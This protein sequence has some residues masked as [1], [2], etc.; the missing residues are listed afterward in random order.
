MQ[1]FHVPL[2]DPVYGNEEGDGFELSEYD[3]ESIYPVSLEGLQSPR[4]FLIH[5]P[6][7]T[8]EPLSILDVEAG[9][10][11]KK[12]RNG[13]ETVTRANPT[14]ANPTTANDSTP[15][16][17]QPISTSAEPSTVIAPEPKVTTSIA[18][19]KLFNPYTTVMSFVEENAD[20]RMQEFHVPLRDPVYGNK[21]GDGFELSEYDQ[22]SI[23]PVSLEGLQ[24]PRRFLIHDP[25]DTEEPLSILDVEAGTITKKHRNGEETVTRANPTPANPTT[26]NDSTPTASQPI[27]T[28]A[29][30][31]TVIAPEPK[32]TT[33][34]A[35]PKLFNPYTTVMSFVEENADPR[36]QE[37]HV[38]LRDPVYGN[39]EGDGFELS[40]YDQE[41]IYPVSLEGLQSP[42]RF[43]IHDPKDTE[44]PLSILDVE[45]G[46]ITKKH[47]NGEETVTRVVT[48]MMTLMCNSA[49]PTPAN[50]TTAN[51]STPT[52][53]QP[54]S[55]SAEPSTVIAPEPKVTTSIAAPKLFNPYT[56]VMSFVE[57]NADPRMQEF[58]VP[59]RDPVYGNEE[60]DGF[61]LSEYD[62][63]SIYP[64]SLEGLQSPRR[65]L[66]HDPKDTEEPLSI[67]DVEAGTITK[68]HRNGEE[69]VTRA[70]PTP[71]N[72]TTAND[73]TPTASQPISTSA[74]PSTV[75]APEPKVTT[76]IA[77]PKLFN[78]YTTVMSFVEENADPRMQ[79]FHVPLRDPVYGNEE[80]DGFELSEYDQES[81]Y[82]VSLEGLQSPRRFLIHDP[83][84]TEEPL[85]ILDVEAGTITK[86]HR[87][88]EETVTRVVTPMMTLMC[89]SANPTPANPTTANDSTPTASQPISTS[90]EPST[91]IAP[92]PKVTTSIAAPKLFNPHTTVMSF[93]E[94]N[95][96]PRMQEFHVPLRDPVY[97]NEEGDGFELSEY[98]Q[99]SIYPVS[100]EGL[101][102][103]RRFLI[104][105]PKDTEEPLS[106]LDVE[107]GTITKKHRNGEEIVTRANPT[108]ANPTTA[109][110]STPTA[111][112]P[113]STSAEPSTVIAPEP[114]V[115]TSIAAPKLFNPYTTVMSFV[116]ENADPRMQEFHVPLRDPV[117]GNEEGDGFELS[118]YDQ[119]SI[120]PVSLEGLQS[121]RRFLIHD[122]KD[123][124]ERLSILDVEA[125]TITKKHRNGEE[126]VTRVVTHMKTLM[127]NS[128]WRAAREDLNEYVK[129]TRPTPSPSTPTDQTPR[130]DLRLRYEIL[131][132]LYKEN[133]LPPFVIPEAM[134]TSCSTTTEANPTPAT[135]AN[136]T[137]AN[138]STPTAS[139]PI[140]T[141]AEP[142]TVIAPEPKVTTSIAAPKLFNPYTTVMSFV[143]ENADP[144]MQ[145][146]HVPLRDPVYGNEEGDGFELSEYDQESIYPVSLEGLQSPRRF[147]IHDPKDTEEPLSILD[148][149]A[150]TITK[151]HRNGEETVTRANPTPA[152][153]TTA[154]DSTP[155][156]SQPISTSAEPSTVIAP[157]PKVTTSIAAPKLFNP[158]TTVMSFVEENADPRMQEF[159]VPLR[160]PVYGNEEGDGFELSE[161]DQESIYPVSL[162]GLQSPRRFLI[163]DPKDTEERLSILDV[164]AGTIT[165]KHR[166]GEETVTRA[167]PTPANPTTAN[168]S[169]PTAS[170]PISTSAEPSTVIAPEPKVTTS[171][172]APK[173]FNPY[174]TV[175][176]F[177]EENADPRMQEFHVPLRDPVYGNEEGDGF[178]L[179][180]YDQES[181]YPVSLEGL[182]SPRR[183]LIHD[184][185]DTEEPLSILD[186]EAGTITK[187]H[188]NGEET[189]TRVVT[190]MKTLM[191]N[192]VWRAARED[193][194][195][196][197]KATRPTPSPSTPTDQTPRG[198]LRLRYEILKELYKENNLPPFVIPEA[199]F[200]SCST[201]TEANPTPA[202][203]ANP[204]TAN[205]STPTAS[206]PISTSAE[207]STVIA[208]EPKLT[209]SIA[210]PKLFNPYTTVMSFVEE[211]ADPRMQE[212]HV[213]LR[214]PV[215]GNEEGDGFELSE[216]DQE[217]IYPVS[218]EGLQSPRRFLIHDPKDTE[219]P[220][221]I[222]D[223]EAGTITKKHR[224]GEET[225]T[226]VVTH[227]K[228]L[229][230]NSVWRAAREDLNEYVKATRPT[231][232]PSTPTDQTPRG[233]L[234]LRY[235]ILKELYKE[236]NLPPFV[237][238]EAMFTSCSTTTE[239]NPTPATPANPTTANDS[240]PTAS[241]PISTSAEPSTVIAPE[242]K[243]TTS[244]AAPKLFNPYTTVMS[245]VEENADPRMQEFHVPLRDPVYGNE[246]GDGF[247][248]SEYDQESIY[249]VSLE[250]LQ[251]PRR[252]LIHDPKDTEEPLS[253][254][255]VEAGTITKKHRNG[256]ETVTR[257]VTHMKT[258][259]CN[260]V[261][262]AAREDLNEY[263]KATR[264]TPSPSTPTDQTPR[265]DLRLRY[266]I[267]KEL[268]KENN[269]PP[270]VIPEAM[271]TS[272]S[273][274]TEA[275]PTP[276]TPANPTTANDSTPT[277]SQP[278]STSAEPS[279]VIAPEPKVTTSIAAP[280]LFNP[281]TT[282]MSFVEENADPR[283]QEFHVP[284]RDPV[285]GNEEGDGFELSEYDQESIYPVSLEGLQS[286]R[287]FLI[288]DPK[289]TEEPLSILDVEAGTITKKHRNGEETVTRVVTH[290]KTLMCNSVWRAAREDLNEYVKATRPTP[291]PS[292]PTD[293]TPRGDLRLRYEIL[294]E[295]YKEN[296]LPPFVI[297]EAMFT[298]C[299]TT[300]EANPT[301]AT[302]ANPTTANDSTPTASQPISTSAEPSTVIAPEPKVTTS[303]AAPKLF[304][305][306]TTVMSF[307]EENADPRMQEFHVPLRDPVYGNE[308]GDG[309]ELSEYDQESIYPVSLEGLQS[310][311]RF[312]IHDP[313]DT[314][315]PLS[316][317]DVEAGTITKKHRNGEETVTR[318]VTH[319]KTL[320]CNS[321]WRA[322]R[323]DLN[324]Y[325]KATRPTP[326]PSTPTD[327]T[328]RGDLRLRYEILKELYKE[329]NLPPFVIPEAMFTCSTTTEANPTPATPANPTTAND[330]TPTASQPI[331]TSAEPSTVIA[332][333]PKVTTS[334]AAPKLFN[335]YT[336]VM[337]F[338]EENADPRMQEFHVPLRDPVYGNE[339][340]DGFE[341]SEYDQ[342]SIYPV[343]L[344]GLQ[345]P[346]R[347]LI[348]DPKDTE[349]PLSILDVEAGTITKK[350]RNGE[351]TVT[352]VVTHMKT[353]MCNSV[354]RAARE[355][356]NEYVKATRPTP[357][358]STPTDQTPRGDLR[359]RY[360]ILKELYKENNLPPF[361]IPEAMFTC[362]TTTEANPTP[363]TPANPT[364]ANDSTP[365]A[366]QPISTSAE[367]STVIAPEPKIPD[368]R[369]QGHRRTIVNPGRGSR[370]NNEET[371]KRRGNCYQG[372]NTHENPDVQQRMASSKRRLERICESDKT[373]TFTKHA[374]RPNSTQKNKEK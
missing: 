160:D 361:V 347:F 19:R 256:E 53:S 60:G 23:Y 253:I 305:P 211:N 331:S 190:H 307:V 185:K 229:M 167:N 153:P 245:F 371:Q 276:A 173:L 142:S 5:D 149:E 353:L 13:E 2:R 88:G 341:L 83:K 57:E 139:Q 170:Q 352:R 364:T 228:T 226:R 269:L 148:V 143:E 45:A 36:M 332:P 358:P 180:E 14:P 306:Y 165:K 325:V 300:T 128:V 217:S 311:R 233:D 7:D 43:L 33:S 178:E 313:K 205:D 216:Y 312:L 192:S 172:A 164:E 318:V 130:G 218:L 35:A 163:H 277:A 285:Y 102:S 136:P 303:I 117:Y 246:E 339:E 263:V 255:D 209:T 196:Y 316:I 215:Y 260:S 252:F 249:P 346:R 104:H 99:E 241:Q 179:S 114:K 110:D 191:C 68:K 24:S 344:E 147:L 140:S 113:I 302:P 267:L 176:S 198:D 284:L 356:L 154:N 120:Y 106:I 98:D 16:A 298:S 335:P 281:Y 122:P 11:T 97:G 270:F 338:V 310:P 184:P 266:E 237:I 46:T 34:I 372:S 370:N 359:L 204:T 363:A 25:K 289:D 62:Q 242:P 65:F 324:E 360:E 49:N 105:D 38:P 29:E 272:C 137:T 85:S 22:E 189:V 76:S 58:H 90:A 17:S 342:E 315:E 320:M 103:P 314:E 161:Y 78:P 28:S 308:E 51:D 100:L 101:Q 182:Q 297:P 271:F 329:N 52:A 61:E 118:E 268:Y 115:T 107:A 248:L 343:S 368:S 321:V 247:E 37:F 279:T 282:V 168:D 166:N 111:S 200:T 50:P 171:I 225:V 116:E 374:N 235:E 195:E 87:N 273:T 294:K 275:N 18:A 112:Q 238:P 299:S 27:S 348:H 283:M 257:V 121:P 42:R 323:E 286:P 21:E 278:I 309:F 125:G 72:P 10:I 89:N 244:I 322:A 158:Y 12:H 354:W 328:P 327:Q 186:V 4:R 124:E 169:T 239:A 264:P 59:L 156:A 73:S 224:N 202:T 301:P 236:N 232:S 138:D 93:V 221:S 330:S 274:T 265:G 108:P 39:E 129:A 150:G 317:L 295:L 177:V 3:Q 155:T 109:N 1:E 326:S 208:P 67:L 261:W 319:M 26:A 183:F 133:N 293:Q 288:H 362:S 132:E 81:I 9:T 357:S 259:M 188:R 251:S 82:P 144:R 96:D 54:I 94:E 243:V 287:R 220:L 250:G 55:T 146:F 92:E 30:P 349:E 187:K 162:E 44:E 80:G 296:N 193:L 258:L 71:A 151:K 48:P 214:D 15:T 337:S 230:C 95:A 127:C 203:P 69:T 91:V 199:M 333:E 175:M 63:E 240:T 304:N 152:N 40:K 77:A 159:H 197:V 351:E 74:E 75:I 290:M 336:T 135:P 201:T 20:P 134:F 174:T 41:S 366:S 213:P 350:H 234:R 194:N 207:P 206:Q 47:R 340:G 223:V 345:S 31:S 84:D 56:T 373:H 262:R 231:P 219:E 119:E 64:V 8:E 131:K 254:L 280:K 212:F 32:V 126:T 66:I 227:M 6:K 334:I 141:S 79:E 292:T 365:T 355:D 70:N 123:T 367:P 291:S 369:P 181:I 145:E 210:A 157:E 86:K 222:L